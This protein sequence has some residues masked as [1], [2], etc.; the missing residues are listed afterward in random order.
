MVHRET[1]GGLKVKFSTRQKGKIPAEVITYLMS[2]APKEL[3]KKPSTKPYKSVLQTLVDVAPQIEVPERLLLPKTEYRVNHIKVGQEYLQLLMRIHCRLP[4]GRTR[5]LRVLID[6]GA[7]VNLIREGLVPYVCTQQ[8]IKPVRLMAANQ[9]PLPGGGRC[10]TVDMSF[11]QVIDRNILPEKFVCPAEFY[12][13]QIDVDAI[14]ELSLARRAENRRL[15]PP[16]CTNKNEAQAHFTVWI[17][18]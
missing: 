9:L 12:E 4:N 10:T 18:P 1:L 13:A 15:S 3:S 16:V 11:V 8:A 7:Q 2:G 14:F 17:H 5:K 6:T